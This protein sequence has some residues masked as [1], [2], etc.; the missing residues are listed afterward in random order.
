MNHLFYSFRF[1]IEAGIDSG[2]ALQKIFQLQMGT[3]NITI[4]ANHR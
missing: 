2:I 4:K 3:K 1:S